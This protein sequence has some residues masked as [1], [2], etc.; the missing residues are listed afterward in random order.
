[1]NMRFL[2]L[3][4]LSPLGLLA[5]MPFTS[6]FSSIQLR[7]APLD[8]ALQMENRIENLAQRAI[9]S[10][11]LGKVWLQEMD[12]WVVQRPTLASFSLACIERHSSSNELKE[13]AKLYRL[14]LS[15]EG[16]DSLWINTLLSQPNW[17]EQPLV[18]RQIRLHL[19]QKKDYATLLTIAAHYDAPFALAWKV[20]TNAHDSLAKEI[21]LLKQTAP[22]KAW[23]YYLN[24]LVFNATKAT[25][26]TALLYADSAYT[27]AANEKNQEVWFQLWA[28]AEENGWQQKASEWMAN[29]RALAENAPTHF[30]LFV[31][32][33]LD[34]DLITKYPLADSLC[35]VWQS[36]QAENKKE[37]WY[38]LCSLPTQAIEEHLPVEKA[39]LFPWW[40]A[41][42]PAALSAVLIPLCIVGWMKKR[43]LKSA[44]AESTQEKTAF[45]KEA[46]NAYSKERETKQQV[47]VMQHALDD[48]EIRFHSD[49]QQKAG[50]GKLL[51]EQVLPVIQKMKLD[52]EQLGREGGNALPVQPYL[53]VQNAVMKAQ[54]ETRKAAEFMV[55]E[56]IIA[57]NL[58]AALS[59]LCSNFS[60]EKNKIS[61]TLRGE[62]KPLPVEKLTFLF[63][64]AEWLLEQ[65][66]SNKTTEARAMLLSYW[67]EGIV[68]T[69]E[70]ARLK[71]TENAPFPISF[72]RTGA[73]FFNGKC[74]VKE[75]A[76]GI[77]QV[78]LQIPL[79][80]KS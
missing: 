2:L 25:K 79:S 19:E 58:A 35:Q 24:T 39:P 33:S 66:A 10:D 31:Q 43:R 53:A 4:L 77:L 16:A 65:S 51:H 54:L 61:F 40:L 69:T 68:L 72:V 6:Y 8:T 70:Y 27:A 56:K 1:M 44:L 37:D 50:I 42:I 26:K 76:G 28:L 71:T 32:K 7:P 22:E 55:P 12:T 5:Q 9:Y 60:T 49:L 48:A 29:G 45:K 36:Q 57:Q 20:K 75:A 17:H 52:V 14:L 63:E 64:S 23:Y 67:P 11:S 38:L 62:S 47:S 46:E 15:P 3:L 34:N 59:D 74:E 73:L 41:V 18:S 21:E 13:K 80:L 30:Y 78:T